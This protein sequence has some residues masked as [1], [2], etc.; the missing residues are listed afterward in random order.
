MTC[1]QTTT[2]RTSAGSIRTINRWVFPE[3]D[4]AELL[5]LAADLRLPLAAARLLLRRGYRDVARAAHFLEPK[6]ADM[7]DPFLLR[8]MGPAVDRIRCAISNG[9]R[10]E[11]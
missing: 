11:I 5:K 10:I 9:E 4:P 8:D 2:P 6:L 7:H 3:T 1:S